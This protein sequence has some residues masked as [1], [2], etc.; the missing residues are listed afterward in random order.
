MH[1]LLHKLPRLGFSDEIVM[2]S[3]VNIV[4]KVDRRTVNVEILFV[5]IDLKYPAATIGGENK[6]GPTL[7]DDD[8][9][10]RDAVCR[11][12]LAPRTLFPAFAARVDLQDAFWLRRLLWLISND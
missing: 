4:S 2:E 1:Q 10:R 3:L 5:L 8:L 7:S 11:K 6:L 9:M 12:D